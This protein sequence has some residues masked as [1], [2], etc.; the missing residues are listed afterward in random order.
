MIVGI[1]CKTTLIPRR[2]ETGGCESDCSLGDG[3][4][5]DTA[6]SFFTQE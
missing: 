2:Y 4:S 3:V 6:R 1:A 5:V